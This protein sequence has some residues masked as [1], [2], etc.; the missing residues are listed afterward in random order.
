MAGEYARPKEI[1]FQNAQGQWWF[2][3]QEYVETGPYSS[4]K[5]ARNKLVEYSRDILDYPDDQEV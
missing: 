5:E 3:D 1:I 2:Y 4:E